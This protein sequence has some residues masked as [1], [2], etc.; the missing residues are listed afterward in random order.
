[1]TTVL[2][3]RHKPFQRTA[4]QKTQIIAV[5]NQKGGVSKTSLANAIATGLSINYHV[6]Y[7]IC[8]IDMDGQSTLTSFYP[9][10]HK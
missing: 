3:K 4:K 10:V 6:G 7:K 9:P 5:Q 1:N 8:L 2:K